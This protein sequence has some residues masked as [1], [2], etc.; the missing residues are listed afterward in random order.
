[1][2]K[3]QLE[4]KTSAGDAGK[5]ISDLAAGLKDAQ[6][7]FRVLAGTLETETEANF[8]AQGRPSWVP[9]SKRTL[10][11]RLK[12]N[13]GS[14]LL[15]I[16][17]D[18]G[19][20]AASV[21]SYY[22]ADFAGVGAGGAAS[23]YAAIQ[24]LGGTVDHPA[25]NVKTRLRTDAKGNLL[26]QSVEGNAKNLAVFASGRQKR[27]RETVSQVAAYKTQIPARPYL[28]F[29]GPPESAELQPHAVESVLD[30][31]A[32]FLGDSVR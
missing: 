30:V 16:L 32:R 3:P 31:L 7:L 11:E 24:Q 22:G 13:K 15:K 12:R 25:H 19:I 1:M 17:Q 28:P 5:K 14:S 26:R 8:A 18:R 29:T 27:A 23:D 6:P 20:L 10:A 4:F 2:S 9:L 21:S